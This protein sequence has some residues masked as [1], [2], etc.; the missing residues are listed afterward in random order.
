M[1]LFGEKY[2]DRVRVVDVPGVS[3]ELCGG[4]HV[5]TTGQI[6]LFHFTGESGVA[7]GVRR[8]EAFTGPGAYGAVIELDRRLT[9]AAETL[10]TN[11]EHLARKIEALLEEKKR[12]ERQLETLLREGGTGKGAGYER[13]TLGEVELFIGDSPVTDREGIG[14][15]MDRFRA[16]HRNAIEVLFAA[17]ERPG[18]YV[19]VTDDL[20]TRGIRAG[21]LVARI[22]G[23]SGGKGGGRP[24]FASGGLGDAG[25]LAETRARTPEIIRAALAQGAN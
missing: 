22:A 11:P 21:D 24:H 20:V 10:R 18:V 2:G 17:G 4:T 5:R 1:A 23:V 8:I 13:H 19:G 15:L 9:E 6:G 25:K 7:A 12:L 16:D 14:V 3:K